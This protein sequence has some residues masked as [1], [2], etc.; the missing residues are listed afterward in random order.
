M[1]GNLALLGYYAS[2]GAIHSALKSLSALAGF[3]VG[4][5]VGTLQAHGKTSRSAVRSILGLEMLIIVVCA[6]GR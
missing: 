4:I 5:A 2:T 6:F 3:I 1:T